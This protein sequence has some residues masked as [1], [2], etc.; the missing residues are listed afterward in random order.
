VRLRRWW[1]SL[2]RRQRG[3]AVN[4]AIGVGIAVFAALF[5]SNA[6]VGKVRDALLTWQV[7]QFASTDAGRNILWLDVDDATYRTW[8]TPPITPRDRLCRLIDFAVRGKARVIVVDV[9]VTNPSVPGTF[10]PE[11][12][13]SGAGGAAAGSA[14]AEFLAYLRHYSSACKGRDAVAG[15]PPIVLVRDLRTSYLSN[16]DDGAPARTQRASFVDASVGAGNGPVYWSSPNFSVDD[17]AMI[18]L[19]RLWEPLCDPA[20]VLPSTE[21]LAG[22]LFAGSDV[23]RMRQA[24]DT[25][26]PACAPVSGGAAHTLTATVPVQTRVDVGYP[27]QLQSDAALRRFFYR[28]GWDARSGRASMAAFVPAQLVTEADAQHAFDPSIAAGRIVVI[29]GSYADNPDFHRTPLGMLPGTLILINAIDALIHDDTV[30]ETPLFLRVAVELALILTISVVFL[31]LP[32]IP[33]MLVSS[34]LVVVSALTLGFVFLN[35]GYFID[36]VLP[37]IGIQIHS[38]IDIF[39]H[40][41]RHGKAHA[42]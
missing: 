33:A 17:D 35:A 12:P 2:S 28:V 16:F 18:R 40:R 10:P 21:L 25:F 39:E 22:V 13:C 11:V 9:D 31:Y 26:R 3:F 8:H 27:L 19:W 6:A 14:D 38:F 37:L 24:V 4:V 5:E 41:L 36:P 23:Q 42:A 20:S 15:C 1:S 30:R 7:A 32:A 29:G 34:L